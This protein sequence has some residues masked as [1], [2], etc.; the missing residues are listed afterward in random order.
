MVAFWFGTS[1]FWLRLARIPAVVALSVAPAITTSVIWLLS[2]VWHRAGLF[3]SGAR[4]LPV[5]GVIALSGAALY[6]WFWRTGR[7]TTPVSDRARRLFLPSTAAVVVA[8][9]V[10][11]ILAAIPMMVSAPPINPVQQWDPSFHM[12]G[13][14]AITQNGIAA[15]GEGLASNYGCRIEGVSD[16]MARLH[17]IVRH[18]TEHSTGK[19]RDLPGTDGG[20]GDMHGCIHVVPVSYPYRRAGCAHHCG[21]SSFDASGCTHRLSTDTQR[22]VRCPTAWNRSNRDSRRSTTGGPV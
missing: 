2:E 10:G 19:Q 17:I 7:M 15:P 4:V 9:L 18:G 13:V 14:W 16:W 20:V 21:Y 6:V 5:M 8:C 11:W 22:N 12:N 3:W 1:Y